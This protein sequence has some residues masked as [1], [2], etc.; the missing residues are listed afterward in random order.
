MRGY[1]NGY[2]YYPVTQ[3]VTGVFP[4]NRQVFINYLDEYTG[5]FTCSWLTK[6]SAVV[7]AGVERFPDNAQHLPGDSSQ[8]SRG[9]HSNAFGSALSEA[10]WLA[11]AMKRLSNEEMLPDRARSALPHPAPAFIKKEKII[12][13]LQAA[14]GRRCMQ[15]AQ[16]CGREVL[17]DVQC[18]YEL[19]ET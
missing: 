15:T 6:A 18:V 8:Q 7:S 13:Y 14:E 10:G 5:P 9:R 16:V 1:F 11:T 2:R 12:H 19:D 4:C 3:K 17:H